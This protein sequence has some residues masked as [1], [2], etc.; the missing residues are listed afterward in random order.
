MFDN[1]PCN[2]LKLEADIVAPS[3]THIFNE[4]ICAG[5][6]PSELKLAKVTPI[7]KNGAWSD[8][9]NYGPISV[10]STVTK[11]FEKL[12][13]DEVYDYFNKSGLLSNH[14]SGFR[15]LHSTVTALLEA[16]N[17]WSVNIDNG[18]L[19]GLIFLDLKKDF[20]TIDHHIL[21]RKLSKVVWVVFT[22]SQPKLQFQWL[23]ITGETNHLWSS[24]G[25]YLRSFTFSHIY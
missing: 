7:F 14:Q 11:I 24:S 25:L 13:F 9:N 12:I 17:S 2:L 3:L 19:N 4:S 8:V 15:S 10:I 16:T 18:L 6:F 1:I 20:D 21:L 23:S 22:V 5:I